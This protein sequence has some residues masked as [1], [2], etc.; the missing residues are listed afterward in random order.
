MAVNDGA[1]G[2]CKGSP[3]ECQGSGVTGLN[4]LNYNCH[5]NIII[6]YNIIFL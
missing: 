2:E 6:L 5:N 1:M 3:R 4:F